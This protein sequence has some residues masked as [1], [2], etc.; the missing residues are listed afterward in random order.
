MVLE[1]KGVR[2]ISSHNVHTFS[3]HSNANTDPSKNTV[4]P[5][6]QRSAME[7]KRK[8]TGHRW[9]HLKCKGRGERRKRRQIKAVH[10]I[11]FSKKKRDDVHTLREEGQRIAKKSVPS[12][13]GS[14]QSSQ[15]NIR[16]HSHASS[17]CVVNEFIP[18]RVVEFIQESWS[19]AS[20]LRNSRVP[21]QS[22]GHAIIAWQRSKY[23]CKMTHPMCT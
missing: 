9:K 23:R 18:G 14:N 22:V 6:D 8:E 12:M 1:L 16:S 4:S 10:S 13:Q 2:D 20:A 11:K 7:K 15:L 19:V 5:Q 3:L 17:R 21:F